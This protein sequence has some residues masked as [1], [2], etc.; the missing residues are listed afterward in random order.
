MWEP[1]SI[2][3][4]ARALA[5][6]GPVA[7]VAVVERLPASGSEVAR[8]DVRFSDG[9]P[10]ARVIGKA[11]CG[12][13]AAAVRR[14]LAFFERVAPGWD[15]RAP[16]LLGADGG[17][18]SIVIFTEDLAAAGYASVGP[19]VSAAQLRGAIEGVAALHARFWDA[20]P[21]AYLADRADPTS[22][23]RC[24]RAWPPAS[25]A[26]NAGDARAAAARF[27]AASALTRDE[28]E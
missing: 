3:V 9:R 4:V 18:A 22:V 12:A 23:T 8:L 1:F 28:R 21:D 14:E 10:D 24:A 15:S 7:A 20:I 26:R 2:D 27:T 17:A 19:A 11:A 13:G 5:A 25:I 6:L 16:A